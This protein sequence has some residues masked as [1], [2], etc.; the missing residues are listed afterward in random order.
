[1]KTL[2][3]VSL[4]ICTFLAACSSGNNDSSNSTIDTNSGSADANTNNGTMNAPISNGNTSST[5]QPFRLK[6]AETDYDKNGTIDR[7]DTY[8]YNDAGQLVSV[9][10][11]YPNEVGKEDDVTLYNYD[12][13]H[14][15][16][17]IGPER[18]FTFSYENGNLIQQTD[19]SVF[20]LSNQYQYNVDNQLI[21]VEGVSAGVGDDCDRPFL[22][23][24]EPEI[25]LSY[26][27]GNLK[28]IVT[29]D[30]GYTE[31]FT[32]NSNGSLTNI[33]GID[34][35]GGSGD[36]DTFTLDIT[37]ANNRPVSINATRFDGDT[38]TLELS[39]NGSSRATGYVYRFARVSNGAL[40]NFIVASTVLSYDAEGRLATMDA[41]TELAPPR[42]SF[43]PSFI[44]TF[45]YEPLPCQNQT[46]I[47]PVSKLI[48]PYF[49]SLAESAGWS[50]CNF[51]LDDENWYFA[52]FR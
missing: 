25:Q 50:Q 42:S 11:E 9:R 28:E 3:Y 15:I 36:P 8:S 24:L 45:T 21:N 46:S 43:E 51:P 20:G 34:E 1:M 26:S 2:F 22:P 30:G 29:P 18:S 32:Y 44:R 4:V 10:S 31:T 19:L 16:E 23:S 41:T 52:S 49:D 14:L 17:Q 39:L 13:D 38:D 35:C 40:E 27:N 33:S 7:V 6:R 48:A 47:N 37:Y 12:N 5:G